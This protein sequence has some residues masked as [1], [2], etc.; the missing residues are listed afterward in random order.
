MFNIGDNVIVI[1]NVNLT[2]AF[3]VGD[4]FIVLGIYKNCINIKPDYP[5]SFYGMEYFKLQIKDE[6]NKKL[7]ILELCSS[8]E[9]R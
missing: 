9:I 7:K 6:R 8:Q 1:N 4:K 5:Y 2:N 3:N